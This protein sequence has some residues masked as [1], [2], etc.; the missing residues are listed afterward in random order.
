ML[1]PLEYAGALGVTPLPTWISLRGA[2]LSN[3]F[4]KLN[5]EFFPGVIWNPKGEVYI[6]NAVFRDSY[7]SFIPA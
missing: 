5:F 3:L 7:S 1:F 2:K 4:R 6:K